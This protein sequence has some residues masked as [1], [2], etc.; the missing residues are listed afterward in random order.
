VFDVFDPMVREHT[1]GRAYLVE[2][3]VIED[4]KNS[5]AYRKEANH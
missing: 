2:V 4:S 3:A 5:G 1:G